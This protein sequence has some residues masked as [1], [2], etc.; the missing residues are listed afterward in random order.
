MKENNTDDPN[1]VF[2]QAAASGRN[3]LDKMQLLYQSEIVPLQCPAVI[4]LQDL[5]GSNSATVL[6]SL[7]APQA[8]VRCCRDPHPWLSTGDHECIKERSGNWKSYALTHLVIDRE[9]KYREETYIQ[10]LIE[11]RPERPE[12]P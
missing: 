11:E 3:A 2:V 4:R 8:R 12:R 1:A 10:A 9:T 7:D 5:G 6:P